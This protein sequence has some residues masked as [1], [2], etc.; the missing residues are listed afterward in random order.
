MK[1]LSVLCEKLNDWYQEKVAGK[2]FAEEYGWTPESIA[3]RL[4]EAG[5][6]SDPEMVALK[7]R[8]NEIEVAFRV[9]E[10]P[11]T[12]KEVPGLY[13]ELIEIQNKMATRRG[14]QNYADYAYAN[15]YGRDYTPADVAAEGL[16]AAFR[17]VV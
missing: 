17:E 5:Q 15:V 13:E 9:L 8:A 16:A 10:D 14:Y 11:G 1:E 4:E 6:S 3:A 12:A 7:R 2:V